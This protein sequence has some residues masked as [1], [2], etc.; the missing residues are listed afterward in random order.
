MKL[1]LTCHAVNAK[2]MQ[3]LVCGCQ[4]VVAPT[5]TPNNMLQTV[6]NR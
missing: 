6:S 5:Y 4:V 3:K 2:T 1:R